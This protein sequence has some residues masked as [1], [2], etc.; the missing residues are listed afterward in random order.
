MFKLEMDKQSIAYLK[1]LEN[2][3][4]NINKFKE[5]L[6]K[7][8]A[9]LLFDLV[10]N[11]LQASTET[12]DFI[13]YLT[14]AATNTSNELSY[15]VILDPKKTKV[16]T[17]KKESSLLTIKVKN[18]SYDKDRKLLV[19]QKYSPWTLDT[20]PYMPDK[21]FA[22]I[23][24]KQA[25]ETEVRAVK[26]AKKKEEYKWK[27]ELEALGFNF[28]KKIEFS[29]NT[30]VPD[31][32]TEAITKEVGL[33]SSGPS[34]QWSRALSELGR[35]DINSIIKSK[36]LFSILFGETKAQQSGGTVVKRIT[37]NEMRSLLYFQKRIGIVK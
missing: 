24:T 21:R 25:K 29:N 19:L 22:E 37:P 28:S 34:K 36:N 35:L 32:I 6:L 16:K 4:K 20:L 5:A 2:L 31:F 15:A 13:N 9:Q 8:Q 26:E 1:K 23:I 30:A 27:R 33:L 3:P 11:N 18:K 7:T 14:I 17:L 10:K 12:S